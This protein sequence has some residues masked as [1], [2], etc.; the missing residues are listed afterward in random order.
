MSRPSGLNRPGCPSYD[1]SNSRSWVKVKR[2][3]TPR[4][5]VRSWAITFPSTLTVWSLVPSALK[6]SCCTAFEWPRSVSRRRPDAR[7]QRDTVP[8]SFAD[9]IVA[10]S[11]LKSSAFELPV[12]SVR[13]VRLRPVRTSTS[14]R[15][16][17]KATATVRP[18]GLTAGAWKPSGISSVRAARP[19][20]RSHHA[21]V[22]SS[23]A[24]T[25]KRPS[26]V[27]ASCG[28]RKNDWMNDGVKPSS[29]MGGP[30]GFR[31]APSRTWIEA[32]S[33]IT[34]SFDPSRVNAR[35]LARPAIEVTASS[36]RVRGSMSRT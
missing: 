27:S 19:V 30:I 1:C 6:T 21:S 25:A 11:G 16:P 12:R 13:T 3:S 18:S 22:P 33:V 32:D 23:D 35:R 17:S 5:T 4:P 2:R 26:G 28:G 7:S 14:S 9:A 15:P 10:P 20:S 34:T 24:V 31:V 29:L 36:W 8:S